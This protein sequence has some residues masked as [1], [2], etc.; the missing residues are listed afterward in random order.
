MKLIPLSQGYFTQVDDEDFDELSKFSW[1][2]AR[3]KTN[4]YAKRSVINEF[5]GK[6]ST[7]LMH[8]KM[9]GVTDPNVDVDHRDNDGLNNQRHN[10]RVCTRSQNNGNARPPR[11]NKSGFKGVHYDK[12]RHKW[13]AEIASKGLGRFDT[14]E[15]AARHYNRAAKEK[16]GDFA[17]LNNVDP[18]FPTVEK[19]LLNPRNTSGYVGVCKKR[20]KWSAIIVRRGIRKNLGVFDRKEDAADAYL[21]AAKSL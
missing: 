16:W 21:I 7:V 13:S 14:K 9:M 4:M 15:E 12:S 11:D 17:K 3:G 20:G 8:R 10:L 18:L 19:P 2:L 5:T 1:N 6:K